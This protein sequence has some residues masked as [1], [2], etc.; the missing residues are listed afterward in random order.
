M[1]YKEQIYRL[2]RNIISNPQLE[3]DIQQVADKMCISRSHLQ[4]L[5][6]QL[7]SISIKDDIISARIKRAMQLLSHTD[8]RVQEIA[9][10]CGYHNENHFMRQFKEKTGITA[11]HYRKQN[12]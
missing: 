12:R 2:R 3:W 4:R 10:Q 1:D 9:L 8:M 11:S 6:K 7:F 5:Y